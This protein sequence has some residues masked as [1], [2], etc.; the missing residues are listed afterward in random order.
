M[1]R[2]HVGDADLAKLINELY[3]PGAQIGSG[4]TASAVRFEKLT[5]QA[6]GNSFHTQKAEGFVT[7]SE[8]WLRNYDPAKT[9]PGDVAAAENVLRDL[10]NALAGR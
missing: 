9:T 4:N 10:R 1:G 5:G 6:V 2:P 8:K 3:R 7:A